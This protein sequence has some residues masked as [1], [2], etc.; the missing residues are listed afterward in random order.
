MGSNQVL[1]YRY[2]ENAYIVI[3]GYILYTKMDE[4]ILVKYQWFLNYLLFLFEF[5][6]NA[7]FF[8]KS[9]ETGITYIMIS[10]Q[11]KGR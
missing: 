9:A 6:H 7:C 1:R 3:T 11:H 5:L 8:K 4:Q 10:E 2:L